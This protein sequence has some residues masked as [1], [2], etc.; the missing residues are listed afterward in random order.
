MRS[1]TADKQFTLYE[2]KKSL[3]LP[4]LKIFLDKSN[5]DPKMEFVFNRVNN[6]E[7]K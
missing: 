4:E 2:K 1:F 5:D 6:S 7:G 3:D